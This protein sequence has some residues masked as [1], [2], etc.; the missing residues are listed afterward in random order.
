[1]SASIFFFL[2]PFPPTLASFCFFFFRKNSIGLVP[3]STRHT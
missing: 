1:M 2:L 3:V